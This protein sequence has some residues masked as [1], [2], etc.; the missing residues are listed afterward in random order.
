AFSVR[1]LRAAI[2]G[3]S[4]FA[5]A[6]CAP[7]PIAPVA[8]N[9]D[10]L[11]KIG[12]TL[13]ITGVDASDG[14]PAAEAVRLAVE[15]ANASHVV[16]GLTLQ[17]VV[18]NDAVQGMH[19][20]KRGEANLRLLSQDPAVVGII[21]PLNSDVAL[22]EIPVSNQVGIALIS[23]ANTSP[24]LTKGTLA[25]SLRSAH[26][27]Q[28]TYFRVCTTDD[29]QGPAGAMYEY[30]QLKAR[31]AYVVDDTN[32]FGRGLADVWVGQFRSEG[33][34]ILA[35]EHVKSDQA[36][37]GALAAR[38]KA[39]H[40]DLVFFGGESAT[41]GGKF[42][43]ALVSAGLASVPFASGDGI[44]NQEY[45]TIA[46]RDADNSYATVA[47]V[48]ADALPSA[49]QFVKAY[50]AKV[51]GTMGAYAANAYAA[52]QALINAI[53]EAS[54]DNNGDIPTRDS[55]LAKLRAT[56][57][58]NTVV[59]QLSFDENGDTTQH[60]ISIYRAQAGKWNFIYQRD[61][62]QIQ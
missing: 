52:T 61:F 18:L 22:A 2:I 28:I 51:R 60:I 56:K 19:N 42:R 5:L 55:V 49:G 57:D 8:S 6:A 17:T 23:P 16:P 11:V 9:S 43:M 41:G 53:A 45:F 26:P 47:A 38:V 31:R 44:Q 10:T 29:I 34:V 59:G 32:T 62:A 33:G 27:D 40:P 20:V 12:V 50:R 58:L 4:A 3:V 46:G 15:D 14:M 21:G 1:A 25:L 30:Q 35:H 37:Y 36:D 7:H 39:A 13:P 24:G 48:N 54:A